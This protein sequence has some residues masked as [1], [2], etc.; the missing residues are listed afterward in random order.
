MAFDGAVYVGKHFGGVAGGGV[1]K[2]KNES[3]VG[4][5]MEGLGDSVGKV[6]DFLLSFQWSD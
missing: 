6:M 1:E 5:G 3:P 4:A 2:V